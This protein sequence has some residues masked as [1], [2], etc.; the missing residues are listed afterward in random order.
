MRR[1]AF[2]LAALALGPLPLAGCTSIG[3]QRLAIDRSDYANHLRETNKEQLLLNIVAMRYGDAPL[4]LDVSSVI[5]QYTREGQLSAGLGINPPSDEAD[6]SLGG[7]VLLR[8]TPTI[9]YAPLV[10]DRF[11]RS[12]LSPLSPA[13]LLGMIES[14]WSSELLFRVAVR[15]I[16]GISNGARSPLFARRGDESF[17]PVLGAMGRLQRQG[18]L[19]LDVQKRVGQFVAQGR[20]SSDLTDQQR[21]DMRFLRQALGLSGSGQALTILFGEARSHPDELALGTRSM[22]E[23]FSEMAQGVEATADDG[24]GAM[25]RIHSGARKPANPHVAARFRGRWYWI[26]GDDEASKQVFLIAQ[27]L[28][29]LNDSS[30]T[31][32]AP[33]V[34][35]PTG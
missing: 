21:A 29:S 12:L 5:S 28:L 11:A 1:T 16:N 2:L 26:D 25:I 35:I 24:A 4:F 8:E 18:A 3:P 32:T 20:L 23:I 15:T 17:E 31:G 13:A 30:G 19:T 14:G 7:S 33:L 27:V 22:F 6:G 10:G 9:T 34:T